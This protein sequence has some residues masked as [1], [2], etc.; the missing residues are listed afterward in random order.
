[1]RITVA[2]EI[3]DPIGRSGRTFDQVADQIEELLNRFVSAQWPVDDAYA[4]LSGPEH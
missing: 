1:L 2:E 3:L 4:A